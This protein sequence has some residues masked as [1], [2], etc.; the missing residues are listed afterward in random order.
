MVARVP[1]LFCR[2]IGS[3]LAHTA[4][5]WLKDKNA[6]SHFSF[7]CGLAGL[8][9]AAV[10]IFSCL[11]L[12]NL[13]SCNK[14]DFIGSGLVA[15]NLIALLLIVIARACYLH[16]FPTQVVAPR[17]LFWSTLFWTG[18]LLVIIRRA[19]S[20]RQLRWFAYPVVLLVLIVLLPLTL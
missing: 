5:P 4:G 8:T 7:F 16:L 19:E 17:Y 10:I 12:R 13:R 6:F 1:G 15:F 2:L 18:L 20:N 9:L 11:N 14:L 3:P